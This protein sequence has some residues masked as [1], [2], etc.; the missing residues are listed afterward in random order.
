M[1]GLQ[2]LGT[3]RALP[4]HVVTNDDLAKIVDTSDEWIVSRTGI[5]E[6]RFAREGENLTQFAVEAARQA[7]ARAGIRPED[8]GL[9]L[10]GTVTS[11]NATPAQSCLVHQALRLPEDCPAFDLSAGCS[12]FLYAME[13]AAALLPRMSRPYALILG[14]ELLS[15][16]TNMEDRSTCI[17][18]GDGVGAVVVKS[19]QDAPWYAHL[20]A[21]GDRDILWSG[22]MGSE[23]RYLHMNGQEVFKFALETVP[24]AARTLLAKAGMEKE[25]V[26]W[27]VLHQANHRIVESVARRLKVPLSKC[28]ENIERYGNT[29]AGTPCSSGRIRRR[30]NMQKLNEWLGIEFPFIQGGM[31]NI[32]TAE[33]AAAVSNAGALG[34]IGAG[35]MP[36]EVFQESIRRCRS[37]TDKPFGVNI[38]LM[39]PQVEQLAA[40]A[41]EEKVAVITTGA[42]DPTRFIPAWKESGAKVIPVVAAVALAKLVAK[43]GAD[44]VIA[45]G[46]ESGGHVGETTTMALV[47]QVVDA[48]DIPVIA[49]GGIASGRQLL[50]AYALGAIGAQVGT[51]LLVSEECPIHENYKKAVLKAKDRDTVVTG[52]SV[53][54][55]VRC[56]RNQM[57]NAYIAKEKEGADRMELEHF[58]L[59]GLR[60]AVFDGDVKTGSV[61]AGQVAGMLHEIKPLRQIFEEMTAQCGQTLKNLEGM[62][63]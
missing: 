61:M 6:R 44:A 12:G 15:R 10:M 41:A 39:H 8:L 50:A 45:E 55:P 3:G 21:R 26:D 5:K 14:G 24:Q 42:G 35:G 57:T 43:R 9:C 53:D 47:P 37:L 36:P 49:A 11:D 48:V 32:A 40:I 30:N 7:I 22:G 16:I 27:Y 23:E 31:A 19:T 62:G 54:A 58:T 4:E 52:R 2:I 29:S 56:L 17:L 46:T 38:M 28:Y 51:C 1:N 13:T 25:Q 18:F 59:G 33:F 20:G 34:L 60:K 63:L